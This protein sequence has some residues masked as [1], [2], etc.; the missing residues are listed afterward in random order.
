MCTYITETAAILGTA[1][2]QTGWVNVDTANVYYD[3]PQAAPFDHTLNIDFVNQRE[4]SPVRIA[5]ELSADSARLLVEK[6]L[7][8]LDAGAREHAL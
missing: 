8:A 2:G 1:K 7:A 4:G 6:I 3:H 5:V